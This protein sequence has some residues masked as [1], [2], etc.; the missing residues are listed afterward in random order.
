MA[1]SV[2]GAIGFRWIGFHGLTREP[3]SQ[4]RTS[5]AT[6]VQR[7]S[8]SKSTIH[9]RKTL[10]KTLDGFVLGG[11]STTREQFRMAGVLGSSSTVGA[12]GRTKVAAWRWPSSALGGPKRSCFTLTTRP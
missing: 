5:M 11:M 2:A 10:G 3:E 7:S 4:W 8:F 1:Q 9:G 6:G 12:H